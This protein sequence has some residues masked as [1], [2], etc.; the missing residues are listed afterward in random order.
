MADE[1]T[2]H[3]FDAV[4]VGGGGAG[5]YAALELA[6]SGTNLA[7]ISK[8]YPTRSHTGA[9]QGGIGAALGNLEEDSW[10]WHAF[11][12]V[13]GS[14]YL[15]DQDAVNFMCQ[16]AIETVIELEHLGLPFSR[17]PEGKIAQRRFGGH[18]HHFGKGPVQ[19]SC[20]A[21]DR[22]GHMILQT[23]YQNCVKHNVT[24]FDEFH[25][26]DLIIK[27]GQACGVVAY[28]IKTGR[29][30]IF[31]A[32]GVILATGGCGRMFSITSNAHA[33]TGDGMAIVLDKG[34]PLEDMEFFQFHPTGIYKLGILLSEAARGEG[35]ILKNFQGER[36]MQR[37]SP[38]M[39]DLAPR[40]IVSRCIYFE[41]REKRG[42]QGQ[43][44]VHLDLT[45]LGRAA[46]DQ[47]LPDI[48]EFV[49]TY[50]GLE[51]AEQPIP[52]QP[53]AHYAMGGVPTNK[54]SRVL[55]NA[56]G[57]T[58]PG[59]Y[60]AGECACVSVHGANRLGTNSLVDILV[61][62]RQAG[63]SLRED[64]PHLNKQSLSKDA[65]AAAQEQ[66]DRF[67]SNAKES[68]AET[69]QPIREEL[70]QEMMLNCG[71]FRTQEGLRQC[72]KKIEGLK[73]RIVKAKIFDL[74]TIFNTEILEAIELKNLINLAWVTTASALARNESRG[75]HYREDFPKRDDSQWLKH[76]FAQIVNKNI[77]FSCKPVNIEQFQP[78]ERKY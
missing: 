2:R 27:D 43:D 65:A 77:Q 70:R 12:T 57:A 24:F 48:T 68:L 28:E 56:T 60:A 51:P 47:K 5:L 10:E 67:R 37:Y 78:Q 3:S 61:F 19:R 11:D 71:V 18:S 64:L 69:T 52:V 72:L 42:I 39:L 41:V 29:L 59:L 9:A 74:G 22:T 13:K 4:I 45:H 20:Y 26:L 73:E 33:L 32:T 38:T 35:G 58:L 76:T 66:L 46:L 6:K 30:H 7:V 1:L 14:D 15:A 62:G 23:L 21:A 63:R 40:D 16:Q 31:E 25:I 8:L 75:G 54:T 50:M 44:Y 55:G 34:L 17:T 53:T 49:R 36:F